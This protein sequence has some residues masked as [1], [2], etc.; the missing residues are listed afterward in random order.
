[1]QDERLTI[2][3]WLLDFVMFYRQLGFF[4]RY[5]HLTEL[6]FVDLLLEYQEG[7]E[8]LCDVMDDCD[9]FED[10][11]DADDCLYDEEGNRYLQ[12]ATNKFIDLRL[13]GLLDPSRVWWRWRDFGEDR[14]PTP[15]HIDYIETIYLW[16]RISRGAFLPLRVKATELDN[17]G[18]VQ[19]D[20]DLTIYSRQLLA[21]PQYV[22]YRYGDEPQIV[23]DLGLLTQINSLI[24]KTG[25]HFEVYDRLILDESGSVNYV[26][27]NGTTY[28]VVLTEAE[29]LRIERERG[30]IF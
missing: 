30:W 15:K 22:D 4:S 3:K 10:I 16:S 26:P 18:A 20:F 2:R 23:P 6:E 14:Y 28:V 7:V 19:I 29:Q 11:F 27:F 17:S 12:L 13:L 25:F 24:A 5:N 1:M 8:E 9:S 21:K